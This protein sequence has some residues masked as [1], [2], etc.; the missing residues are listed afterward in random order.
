MKLDQRDNHLKYEIQPFLPFLTRI[1]KC[2]S[3]ALLLPS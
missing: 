2:P 3:V 1:Q